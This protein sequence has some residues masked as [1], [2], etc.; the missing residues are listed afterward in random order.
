MRQH[1]RVVAAVAA[2]LTLAAAFIASAQGTTGVQP[3]SGQP[4][5]V[6]PPG[7]HPISGRRFA[8][9]MDF[10]GLGWLDRADRSREEAPEKAL[11]I[12][13]IAKGS[14][15]AD[16]GAGSGYYTTRLAARVGPTGL[17]YANDLQPEMLEELRKRV[18]LQHV[19]NVKIVPGAA[20]DPVLMVDVYHEF[21][22]PQKMLRGIRAALKPGGRLVLVEFRREE[23]QADRDEGLSYLDSVI[24]LIRESKTVDEARENMMKQLA[25][26]E[27]QAQGL[28]ELQLFRLTGLERRNLLSG[29][30]HS[31]TAADAKLEVEA[32]GFHLS[33]VEEGLPHQH[34]L[35]FT[36]S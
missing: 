21:S 14:T 34:L 8:T 16:V 33:R 28:L 15:V 9:V 31:M 1:R 19:T 30:D 4:A 25:L 27:D 18:A 17:V 7:V 23:I 20:D 26:T 32:E 35:I 12:I 5:G 3:T 6:Q 11:D 24:K 13:G 36:K 29:L 10:R 22:E 2:A